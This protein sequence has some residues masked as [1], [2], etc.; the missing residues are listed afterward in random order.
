[1]TRRLGTIAIAVGAVAL[2]GAS[3]GD[4]WTPTAAAGKSQQ[5]ATKL[6]LERSPYGRV[7]FAGGYAMYLFTRD[8]GQRSQCRGRCAK[9][10]PPLAAHGRIEA[11]RGVKEHLIGT[12]ARANGRA[13]V[14]YDGHPLYGYVHDPRGEVLCHDVVEFGGTWYAVRKSGKPAP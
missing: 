8:D 1:V 3:S 12:T 9:A 11:G 6:T 13:Q 10:W 5:Q 14:T 2:L 4:E 7:L